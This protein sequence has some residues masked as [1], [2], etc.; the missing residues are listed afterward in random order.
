MKTVCVRVSRS[1]YHPNKWHVGCSA[2]EF[3][4]IED[5]VRSA[6]VAARRHIKECGSPQPYDEPHFNNNRWEYW[7]I[8]C[9]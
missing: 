9:M 3:V 1:I 2:C 5:D 7:I 6:I 8:G 4:A